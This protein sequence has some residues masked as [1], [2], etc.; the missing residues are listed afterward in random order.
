M[1][2]GRV[3]AY[4]RMIGYDAKSL[5]FGTSGMIYDEMTKSRWSEAALIGYDYVGMPT[6]FFL[7]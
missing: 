4:L 3:A 1:N 7:Q 2:R 6:I 5:K